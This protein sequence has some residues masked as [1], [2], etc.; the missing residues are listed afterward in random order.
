VDPI[1]GRDEAD[2]ETMKGYDVL[3]DAAE[4]Q[5]LFEKWGI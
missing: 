2:A 4:R 3:F 5:G 1:A